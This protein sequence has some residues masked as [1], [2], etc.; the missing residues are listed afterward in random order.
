M[1]EPD[2]IIVRP[3]VVISRIIRKEPITLQ[4]GPSGAGLWT[5]HGVP[6]TI[7][8]SAPGDEYLDMDTGYIYIL[9]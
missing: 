9:T 7:I 5:G 2:L 8:G 4:V 1:N 6:S 3:P